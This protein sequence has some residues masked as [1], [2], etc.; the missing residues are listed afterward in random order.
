MLGDHSYLINYSKRAIIQTRTRGEPSKL[1]NV[2]ECV[3]KL[4]NTLNYCKKILFDIKTK[5]TA[6]IATPSASDGITAA[7]NNWISFKLLPD[8]RQIGFSNEE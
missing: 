7:Y 4:G 8:L 5:A 1:L 2:E 6:F 3:D